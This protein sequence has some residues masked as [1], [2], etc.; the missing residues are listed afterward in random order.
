MG[1][2]ARVHA[3]YRSDV[4]H[5][6]EQGRDPERF[7]VTG[8][9]G[10]LG[11]W[12]VKALVDEGVEVTAVCPTAQDRR[13]RLIVGERLTE[14]TRIDADVL[15]GDALVDAMAGVTHVVH[16]ESIDD[17]PTPG[18]GAQRAAREY[19]HLADLDALLG[20]AHA[21]GV[22]GVAYESSMSVYAVGG[23]DV[24]VDQHV[25]PAGTDGCVALARELLA[26]TWSS[27]HGLATVAV[28]VGFAYGPGAD[29]GP[30]GTLA[31]ASAA[32]ID[33]RP[34]ALTVDGV[35]D[36]QFVGDVGAALCRAARSAAEARAV[37]VVG[38]VGSI[39][40]VVEILAACTGAA[41]LSVGSAA[42]V[43]NMA[44]ARRDGGAVAT[45]PTALADGL[46]AT[47]EAVR[48]APRD[49]ASALRPGATD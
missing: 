47:V 22:R 33:N 1:L 43:W 12:T 49:F 5:A 46:R 27:R 13:L 26:G 45:L 28:R 41:D 10:A 25:R 32:A 11:A 19:A 9:A 39:A 6:I 18:S 42:A 16:T 7:L 30:S 29:V 4:D 38:E 48:W 2:S 21:S 23:V 24:D 8:A 3:G 15:A 20:A 37:N 14:V 35:A 40:D 36:L 44:L 17:D 34:H 31:I